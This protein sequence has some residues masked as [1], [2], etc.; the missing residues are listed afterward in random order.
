ML[1]KLH[2]VLV[3]EQIV[4]SSTI[5]WIYSTVSIRERYMLKN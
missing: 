3:F 2:Y 5:Q 1:T 4:A